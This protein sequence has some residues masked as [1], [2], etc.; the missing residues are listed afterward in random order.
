MPSLL[1]NKEGH[2]QSNKNIRTKTIKNFQ[3]ALACIEIKKLKD[4]YIKNKL[5]YL[6]KISKLDHKHLLPQGAR[7]G[8]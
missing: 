3:T 7:Q 5:S 6:L 4:N 2:D 1:K 8:L